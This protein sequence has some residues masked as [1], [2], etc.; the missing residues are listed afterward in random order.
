[1]MNRHKSIFKAKVNI[2]KK[3]PANSSSRSTWESRS[4]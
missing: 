3:F 1:M 2:D 4:G